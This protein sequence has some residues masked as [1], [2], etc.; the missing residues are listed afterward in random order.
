MGERISFSAASRNI[1]NLPQLP[2]KRSKSLLLFLLLM[3][4]R[5]KLWFLLSVVT[6]RLIDHY[7]WG[8][9]TQKHCSF[10]LSPAL[11]SNQPTNCFGLDLLV[12]HVG[13]F[14]PLRLVLV[15]SVLFFFSISRRQSSERRSDT[16]GLTGRDLFSTA[17]RMR[18]DWLINRTRT[19]TEIPVY[20]AGLELDFHPNELF[21]L[22][23][24]D[25]NLRIDEI[26]VR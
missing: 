2:G 15:I 17:T 13:L 22:T 7:V 11:K 14:G 18:I 26:W 16:I 19:R 8:V 1:W 24:T 23:Q 9:L 12:R 5:I 3:Q 21:S 10:G 25:M 6:H 20:T 4:W